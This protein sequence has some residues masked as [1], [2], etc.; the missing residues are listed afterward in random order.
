M[1]IVVA[2]RSEQSDQQ[3][4]M[5]EERDVLFGSSEMLRVSL[6]EWLPTS[7]EV[8]LPSPPIVTVSEHSETIGHTPQDLCPVKYLCDNL[9][10]GIRDCF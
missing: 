7:E 8:V 1:S 4:C 2:W 9:K 3:V 10:S 6:G 5:Q